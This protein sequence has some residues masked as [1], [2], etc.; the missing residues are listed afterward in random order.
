MRWSSLLFIAFT[1]VAGLTVGN[2]AFAQSGKPKPVSTKHNAAPSL[3]VYKTKKDYSNNVPIILSA[4]KHTI[5][6][7]PD[8]QTIKS[9]DHY[10]VPTKLKKGYLLDNRGININVAYLKLT[11]AQYAALPK[12]LPAAEMMKM[13]IDKNPLKE[14]CNC[15]SRY[16]FNNATADLDSIIETGKLKK[17][18]KVLK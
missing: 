4:D 18:C 11:Y 5:V 9:G 1:T 12:A 3:V 8:P 2:S 7:Y 10:P 14:M 13:I 16:A 6:S 15:G 17:T